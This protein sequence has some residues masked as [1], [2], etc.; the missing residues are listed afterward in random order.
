[1]SWNGSAFELANRDASARFPFREG[2]EVS[3]S[4]LVFNTPIDTDRCE[5][6][7]IDATCASIS[8]CR[9]SYIVTRSRYE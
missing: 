1:M 7:E 3:M 9:A 5:Q 4:L 2:D 8:G 6:L